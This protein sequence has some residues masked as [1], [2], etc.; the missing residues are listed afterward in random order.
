MQGCNNSDDSDSMQQF[1]L[2]AG[3]EF[4][5]HNSENEDLLN[6]E[7]PDGLDIDAIRLFYLVDG[8]TVEVYD[9]NMDYP[10]NFRIYQH[11]DE[12]RIGIS[13]NHTE[14]EQKPVTYIQWNESDRDTIEVTY[15]RTQDA[16]LQN[17]IWLNGQQ[18]WERGD[19]SV[20]PYFVL[21][22]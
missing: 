2:Y 1:N 7:N 4:S 21:E 13:L 14:T 18:I 19:N 12:Y 8:K 5:V 15:D 9:S 17:R 6:P 3:L 22:K 16:L 20:D 11:Q 10:R